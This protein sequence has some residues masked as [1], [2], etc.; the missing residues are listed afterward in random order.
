MKTPSQNISLR[1]YNSF[2]IAATAR[3]FAGFTN[4]EELEELLRGA[5]KGTWPR[6]PDLVLGGGSNILLTGDVNGLVLRNEIK[7]IALLHE[8]PEFVYV[9]AGAGEVWHEFVQYTLQRNWAGLENLSLIPGTVGAAPIQN[10]GAYGVELA[11]LFWGL[12]AFHID[13]RKIVEFTPGECAF[14]YRESVFKGK[15]RGQF[16]ILSVTF[17]LRKKPV[18]HTSYGAIQAELERLGEKELT[19]QAISR[20]VISIRQSKLP[21]PAQIG[22]AGSFFKNPEVDAAKYESLK[23]AFPDL[24]AYPLITGNW[25]LAAGW[26]IE[27]CGPPEGPASWKGYRRGDAGVHDRQALVLVNFGVA[28]GKELYNL[29]EDIIRS[30]QKKFAVVL[31]REVNIL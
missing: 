31:E 23:Q 3:W 25:K 13:D 9:R 17:R 2:G 30:V 5:A 27:H 14:G 15:Y 19:I 18:F 26:L 16:I 29:S 7:G 8:D 11:G 12:T 28:S 22:N 24:V 20:A 21:D 1:P 10:I 4:A 6:R